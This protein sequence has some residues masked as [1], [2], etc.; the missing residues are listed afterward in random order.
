MT[1]PNSETKTAHSDP[2]D[3]FN[4]VY[5]NLRTVLDALEAMSLR[6]CLEEHNV[7]TRTDR[8]HELIELI[9][10]VVEEIQEMRRKTG[11]SGCGEGYNNCNGVCVPYACPEDMSS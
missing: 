8:A 11:L 4:R 9:K 5:I 1:E 3:R 2:K 7:T 10:P 6:Y